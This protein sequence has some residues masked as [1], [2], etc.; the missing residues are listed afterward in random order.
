MG[1]LEADLEIYDRIGASGELRDTI[2]ELRERIAVLVRDVSEAAL[3]D[4]LNGALE[5][6]A[7]EAGKFISTLDVERPDDRIS[8]MINDLTVK[9]RGDERDD[10]LWEIESGSNWLSYHIAT[11]LALQMFFLQKVD[12]SPVPGFVVYDQPSQV[13]F[14]KRLADDG[15]PEDADPKLRDTDVEAL[16]KAFRAFGAAVISS[17]GQLQVIVLDHA[18]ENVWSG[19]EGIHEVEEWRQGKKLVPAAWL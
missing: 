18:A 16:R 4:K 15:S 14:P 1:R 7:T 8:L 5:S 2:A 6:V 3:K 13:Y 19:I 10:Y 9:V 11:S 12:E 17:K